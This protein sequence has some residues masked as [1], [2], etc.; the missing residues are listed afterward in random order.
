MAKLNHCKQPTAPLLPKREGDITTT[1]W[2]DTEAGERERER[3][4]ESERKGERSKSLL[5][6]R[7][8]SS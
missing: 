3:E 4:R 2:Q 7:E 1:I 5:R 6:A 8:T